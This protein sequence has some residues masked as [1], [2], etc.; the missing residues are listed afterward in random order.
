MTRYRPV[1]PVCVSGRGG[2]HEP[3]ARATHVTRY[4]PV[5]PVF[6]SRRGGHH[7]PVARA[8]HV[9]RYRPVKPVCVSRGGGGH[10]EPVARATHVTGQD[11]HSDEVEQIG[12]VVGQRHLNKH[13]KIK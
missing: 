2:H 3:V 13:N 5:K 10:H 6:V 4:R 11:V 1:K 9:T 8:A 7:E 12:Q